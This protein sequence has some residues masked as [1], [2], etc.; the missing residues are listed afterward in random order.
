MG[1]HIQCWINNCSLVYLEVK[2]SVALS[3]VEAKYMVASFGRMQS[4]LV[5]CLAGCEAF[6]LTKFLMGL[7]GQDLEPTMIPCD[8]QS[9]IKLWEFSIS[10]FLK[11]HR[12]MLSSHHGHFSE[13]YSYTPVR[14]N[15]A[16]NKHFDQGFARDQI[17]LPQGE[18]GCRCSA[19]RLLL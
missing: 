5:A 17:C 2:T 9:C 11:A 18:V 7:F 6:W 4:F 16:D 19:E 13:R 3:L 14:I 12:H 15:K 10:Q 1:L 8:N